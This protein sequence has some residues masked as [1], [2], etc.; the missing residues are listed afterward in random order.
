MP[1]SR[2]LLVITCVLALDLMTSACPSSGPTPDLLSLVTGRCL[3]F[4]TFLNPAAMC[5][6]TTRRQNCSEMADLFISAF[7]FQDVCNISISRYDEFLEATN[8]WI[9][10]DKSVFWEGVYDFVHLYTEMGKRAITLEDTLTGYMID[11]LRFCADPGQPSGIG[12]P[13]THPCPSFEETDGCPWNA[14]FAFWTAASQN[15]AS[16]ARGTV[17]IMLNASADVAFPPNSFFAQ[18]ELPHLKAG[19]VSEANILLVHTPG[20]AVKETCQGPSI[21]DLKRRLATKNISATCR[22]NP[23]DVLWLLCWEDPSHTE[24]REIISDDTNAASVGKSCLSVLST[25][26][27]LTGIFLI[28]HISQTTP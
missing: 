11:R 1:S 22:E 3:Q 16:K 15:F 23:R 25:L 10:A 28:V 20:H 6:V 27:M 19:E 13:S 18:W 21:T 7:A 26:V 14:E 5:D 12:G 2:G 8:H 9:P 17:S 4:S 24:C